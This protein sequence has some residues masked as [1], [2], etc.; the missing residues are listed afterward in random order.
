[1]DDLWWIIDSKSLFFRYLAWLIILTFGYI[2][3]LL[4]KFYLSY[5]HY[6]EDKIEMV[7]LTLLFCFF[8]YIFMLTFYT[9]HNWTRQNC[10]DFELIVTE[11]PEGQFSCCPEPPKPCYR[12]EDNIPVFSDK[13]QEQFNK[14][15]GIRHFS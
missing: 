1:V 11:Q 4:Y 6:S 8:G 14:R 3:Y 2:G 10:V 13:L 5:N 9:H 7:T 15:L 12:K